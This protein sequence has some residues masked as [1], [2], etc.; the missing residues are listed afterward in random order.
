MFKMQPNTKKDVSDQKSPPKQNKISLRVENI[1]ASV[2]LHQKISLEQLLEKYKDI[3]EKDN[4]PGLVVKMTKPKATILLFSSGKLVMTGIRLLEHIPIIIDKITQK[5]KFADIELSQTP[6]FHVEN[7]VVRGDFH[8]QINLDLTSLFLDR[9][10]YEPEVFPGLIYK[11]LEPNP[12][13]FLLFSSGRIICTGANDLGIVKREV[14]KLGITLK[15]KN[16]L[17]IKPD[18]SPEKMDIDVL[19]LF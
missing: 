15:N 17:G 16:V 11:I 2:T 12:I 10:I 3:E 8:K 1:V 13:C 7:V 4:F 14:K 6:S 19:D 9:A 5:L 18:I